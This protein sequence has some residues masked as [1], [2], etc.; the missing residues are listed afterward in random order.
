V[1]NVITNSKLKQVN[2]EK[3]FFDKNS[4]FVSENPPHTHTKK[5]RPQIWTSFFER[6]LL[7]L[8]FLPKF[9][10]QK[11]HEKYLDE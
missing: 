6:D 8:F 10:S 5:K 4:F 11:V 3:K 2:C 7:L 9:R 1:P